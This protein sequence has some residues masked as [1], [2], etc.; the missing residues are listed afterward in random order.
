MLTRPDT[1]SAYLYLHLAESI[2]D[3]ILDQDGKIDVER[4]NAAIEAWSLGEDTYQSPD[5]LYIRRFIVQTEIL[6]NDLEELELDSEQP[7]SQ[8]YMTL[9]YNAAK[10]V[11]DYD[12][13]RLREYFRW[14]YLVVFQREDGPRWGEFVEVYGVEEFV[15]LVRRRF[16]DLI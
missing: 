6:L 8:Q 16:S 9:F 11:F 3:A 1:F 15:Q 7:V 12:K 14:L 4:D 10:V 13:S 2:P 5:R